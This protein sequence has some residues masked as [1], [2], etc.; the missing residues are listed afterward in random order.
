MAMEDELLEF[1]TDHWDYLLILYALLLIS[2]IVG[3]V[4]HADAKRD[5]RHATGWFFCVVILNVIGIV[6][7]LIT[8]AIRKK[9]ALIRVLVDGSVVVMRISIGF[10]IVMALTIY[11][12]FPFL[13][14][15]YGAITFVQA[16]PAMALGLSV[17]TALFVFGWL[18]ATNRLGGIATFLT[19]AIAIL[20]T[21][22]DVYDGLGDFVPEFT[23]F[24]WVAFV[25]ILVGG[26][27]GLINAFGASYTERN[28][29]KGPLGWF[30]WMGAQARRHKV[31]LIVALSVVGAM[32]ITGYVSLQPW[33]YSQTITVQPQ[34]YPAEIAF[35]GHYGYDH[36]THAQRDALSRHN[37]TIVFYTTPDIRQT[38]QKQYFIDNMN[39]WRASYSGVKFIAAIPGITRINNTGDD[40][41]DFLWGG[42]AWDG[43]VE[44]TIKYAKEFIQIAKDENLTNFIGINTD[45]E[46]PA[47]VLRDYGVDIGP[48]P[49][50]H[51]ASIDAYNEFFAWVRAN[52][53]EFFMTSTMGNEPFFDAF[54]GDNDLHVGSMWNVLDVDGWDEIAPMIYRC[55][56][57]GVKPFGDFKSITAGTVVDGSIEVYNKLS[58]LNRSLTV[59]DGNASR[60]GIYLGIT[61]CTCYGRDVDQYDEFGN[62]LGKGYDELVRDALIAKAFG[63]RIITIFILDTVIENGYSMGGVFD[64]WGD[65]FLDNFNASING[66]NS[67]IPFEIFASPDYEILR[68]F[69]NDLFYNMGRPAGLAITLSIIGVNAAFSVLLHPAL[70]RKWIKMPRNTVPSTSGE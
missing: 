21:W 63:A 16:W 49:A 4:V 50:R 12:A 27:L 38:S 60:L 67:T 58:F 57:K 25:V 24:K 62:Y 10:S 31:S 19:S 1:L 13:G 48:D 42:F 65:G 53:S 68:S 54:D 44:G 64:T 66:E 15:V 33:A 8:K 51:A 18:G 43:A 59:V 34:D 6:A 14:V 7:Y 40:M 26:F 61:N 17:A 45:Q 5:G 11:G 36:Y 9:K 46:S 29:F 3:F 35:W 41:Q 30:R 28:T 22:N 23:T 37:A 69:N 20:A 2:A 70:K 32:S 55:G 56:Y 52:A 47:E 39:A